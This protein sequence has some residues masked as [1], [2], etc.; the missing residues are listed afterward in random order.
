MHG[1][2][3]RL[4]R[5]LKRERQWGQLFS[6]G[7]MVNEVTTFTDSDWAGCKE[8]R[9]SFRAGVILLCNHS[10]KAYTRKQTIIAKSSA[11]AELHAAALGAS[12]LKGIVSLLKDLGFELKPLLAIDGSA[13]TKNRTHETH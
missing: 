11:E 7:K 6:Y 12:E 2:V 3:D 9:K 8:T 13:P 10:Q 1:K 4:V 5:N